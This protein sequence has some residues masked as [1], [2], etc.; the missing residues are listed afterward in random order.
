M[1]EKTIRWV[2]GNRLPLII[3]LMTETATEEGVVKED[4]IIPDGSQIVVTLINVYVNYTY[5][6]EVV[7]ESK[8]SFMV[9][10]STV[11]G[12]YSIEVNVKEPDGTPRRFRHPCV[13]SIENDN[14]G[15]TEQW[16]AFPEAQ[17][18]LLDAAIFY[19]AKGDKGAKG[20]AFTYD[21]FTPEQ[22]ADLQR[23]AIEGKQMCED[24]IAQLPVIAEGLL[25]EL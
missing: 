20:D 1:N 3:P 21:D 8:L 5:T 2:R 4:Y 17:G 19:F 18:E 10:E 22:I 25:D 16:N 13:I 24:A 15:I 23:P 14:T 7:E 11:T 6:P 12:C 9:D